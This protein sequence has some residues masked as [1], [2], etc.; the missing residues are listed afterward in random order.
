MRDFGPWNTGTRFAN[1]ERMSSAKV[2]VSV[3]VAL[4]WLH[5]HHEYGPATQQLRILALN[6]KNLA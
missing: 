2:G 6:L 5:D 1:V 4:D 3:I